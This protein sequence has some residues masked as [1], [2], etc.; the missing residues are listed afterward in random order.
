M[1]IRRELLGQSGE[2]SLNLLPGRLSYMKAKVMKTSCLKQLK[3][4]M[5]FGTSLGGYGSTIGCMQLRRRGLGDLGGRGLSA[6]IAG[7]ETDAIFHM[8]L[9][10]SQRG[11]QQTERGIVENADGVVLGLLP[12]VLQIVTFCHISFGLSTLPNFKD[13]TAGL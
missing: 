11:Q 2:L 1:A 8:Q 5:M 10:A 3:N 6:T 12:R 7:L 13:I 4:R 9:S